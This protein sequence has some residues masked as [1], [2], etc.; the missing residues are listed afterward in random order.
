MQMAYN[1]ALSS[2]QTKRTT[3]VNYRFST[4]KN[5]LLSLWVS[6]KFYVMVAGHTHFVFHIDCMI[7]YKLISAKKD[8]YRH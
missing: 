7:Y 4:F 5:S 3:Y 6:Y 8:Y 1:L 2:R